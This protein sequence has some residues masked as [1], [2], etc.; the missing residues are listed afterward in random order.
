MNMVDAGQ[1]FDVFWFVEASRLSYAVYG[2]GEQVFRVY[3]VP[4]C[5]CLV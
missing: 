5:W 3:G 2:Q 1:S 4:P